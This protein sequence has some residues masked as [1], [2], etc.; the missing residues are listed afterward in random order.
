MN[1]SITLRIPAHPDRT[2]DLGWDPGRALHRIMNRTRD[3]DP[4]LQFTLTCEATGRAVS[5]TPACVRLDR[6]R[7]VLGWLRAMADESPNA[8]E[9]MLRLA[10][11]CE[12]LKTV[13]PA[14]VTGHLFIDMD[15]VAADFDSAYPTVFGHHHSWVSQEV[16]WANIDSDHLFYS[17]LQPMRGF[18]ELYAAIKHLPHSFLSVSRTAAIAG[19][20]KK[21][22]HT[23][24][25][26]RARLIP[27]YGFSK[28]LFAHPG[29]RL[30]DDHEF[31][32]RDFEKAGGI[33]IEYTDVLSVANA[34]VRAYAH[35]DWS[36]S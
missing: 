14:S 12:R 32:I 31:N 17:R 1:K 20:K 25:D 11:A 18:V 9:Y 6:P 15:G 36:N 21:W 22:L 3:L 7:T 26:D 16:M 28:G 33:G 4:R 23:H 24:L 2:R 13:N 27:V 34:L 10:A 29:D 19:L 30:I 35:P 8:Q 5:I